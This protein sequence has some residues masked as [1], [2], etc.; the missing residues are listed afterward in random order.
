MKFVQAIPP[1]QMAI[2]VRLHSAHEGEHD[3]GETKHVTKLCDE[4][5][6]FKMCDEVN[7]DNTFQNNCFPRLCFPDLSISSKS[8]TIPYP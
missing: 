1:P 5:K 2:C 8:H 4:V 6:S 3:G 7:E